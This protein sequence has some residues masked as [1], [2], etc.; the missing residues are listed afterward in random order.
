MVPKTPKKPVVEEEKQQ[1]VQNIK[2]PAEKKTVVKT[3][4]VKAIPA[5]AAVKETKKPVVISSSSS[6]E[7]ESEEEIK[8][9]VQSKPADKKK[10]TQPQAP[11]AEVK[12]SVPA[13][14]VAATP[15]APSQPIPEKVVTVSREDE[16]PFETVQQR[17]KKPVDQ[18]KKKKADKY[19]GLFGDQTSSEEESESDLSEKPLK[20]TYT[21]VPKQ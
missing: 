7:E 20:T 3:V 21:P 11:K 6:E 4:A 19:N 15:K 17:V 13:K 16:M 8:V 9:I 14:A 1:S 10:N 5:K 12:A 18:R 2:T